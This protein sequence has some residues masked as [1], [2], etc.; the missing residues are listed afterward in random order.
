MKIPSK[1]LPDL[2]EMF[3]DQYGI[4]FERLFKFLIKIHDECNR[5]SCKVRRARND[6]IRETNAQ[7]LNRISKQIHK[8]TNFVANYEEFKEKINDRVEKHRS[9]LLSNKEITR[10]LET[11]S[12]PLYGALLNAIFE[13]TNQNNLISV[14]KFLSFIDEAAK[15]KVQAQLTKQVLLHI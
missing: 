14:N 10:M 3:T 12:I 8:D 5:D 4:D 6:C 15:E 7:V 13:R 11:C 9:N 2:V 1:A